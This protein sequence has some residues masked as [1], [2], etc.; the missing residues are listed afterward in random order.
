MKIFGGRN[1]RNN[2]NGVWKRVTA[3]KKHWIRG[4]IWNQ[5]FQI[6]LNFRD[7]S[8][9]FFRFR[10]VQCS[11]IQWE[12]NSHWNSQISLSLSLVQLKRLHTHIYFCRM[13]ARRTHIHTL[14]VLMNWSVFIFMITV[15]FGKYEHT[16]TET[17]VLSHKNKNKKAHQKKTNNNLNQIAL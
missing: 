15:R 9:R 5:H 10:V 14:A 8:L 1:C 7:F 3:K 12:N 4:Q 2:R 13:H 17:H 16:Y 6:I 11:K